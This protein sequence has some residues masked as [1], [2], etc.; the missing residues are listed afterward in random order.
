M[1]QRFSS[2]IQYPGVRCGCIRKTLDTQIHTSTKD[3]RILSYMRDDVCRLSASWVA[4]EL[5]RCLQMKALT[6]QGFER[7]ITVWKVDLVGKMRLCLPLLYILYQTFRNPGN[8]SFVWH[9]RHSQ[10]IHFFCHHKQFPHFTHCTSVCTHIVILHVYNNCWL[11]A[12]ALHNCLLVR[13]LVIFPPA[14]ERRP[15]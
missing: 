12:V 6:T 15:H 1:Y 10:T 2:I 5:N 3:G 7:V 11:K 9:W 4:A 8:S 14:E 13:A